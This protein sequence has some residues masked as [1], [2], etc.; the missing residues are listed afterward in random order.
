MHAE[1]E[2]CLVKI[3]HYTGCHYPMAAGSSG[4]EMNHPFVIILL[5]CLTVQNK[6][7]LL[8]ARPSNQTCTAE[9]VA[10]ESERSDTTPGSSSPAVARAGLQH[11]AVL[12]Q[13]LGQNCSEHPGPPSH[14]PTQTTDSGQ[15]KLLLKLQVNKNEGFLHNSDPCT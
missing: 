11:W 2:L 3:Y 6:L 4:L 14:S 1:G 7:S 15:S 12:L 5:L 8:S 13:L 10:A 9:Y